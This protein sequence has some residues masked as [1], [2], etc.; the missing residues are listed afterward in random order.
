MSTS[1]FFSEGTSFAP[2]NIVCYFSQ[3]KGPPNVPQVR[4]QEDFASEQLPTVTGTVRLAKL[5]AQ[6]SH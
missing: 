3:T 5:Y 1:G 4:F 2:I 6:Q